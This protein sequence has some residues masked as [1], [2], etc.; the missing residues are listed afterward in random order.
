MQ[1]EL[2]E[3]ILALTPTQVGL[4]ATRQAAEGGI[5]N[6]MLDNAAARGWILRTRRGVWA[7]AG[8]PPSPW[9]DIY[10]AALAAG[11]GAAISHTSA[12]TIQRLHGVAPGQ[13]ELTVP[14]EMNRRLQGV[15]THRSKTIAPSDLVAR[16]GVAVTTP[17]RTLIDLAPRFSGPLLGEIIDEG[18][19]SR[20]WTPESIVAR[21]DQLHGS[22]AGRTN[23]SRALAVRAGEGHPDS[24][25]EQRVFRVVKGVY[26]DY[27]LHHREYLDGQF[28]EIDIAWVREKIA[29]EVEGWAT[30]KASRIKFERS[31]R[32]ENILGRHGWRIVHFTHQMDD[33]TIVAQLAPLF[34]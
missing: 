27:T 11:P 24:R 8:L 32:R 1:R 4:F 7:I 15:R 5:T 29:G 6:S 33:R 19:I 28:I 10:A 34:G 18:T 26:P 3:Q 25:L 22:V 16:H 30:R 20:L 13:I 14:Y 31:C 17:V 23:L 9:R 12:A 2:L 21:L